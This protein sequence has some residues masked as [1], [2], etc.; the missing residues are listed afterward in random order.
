MNFLENLQEKF[1]KRFSNIKQHEILFKIIENTFQIDENKIPEEYR[2]E[3]IDLKT[4]S[5]SRFVS[6]KYSNRIL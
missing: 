4:N 3:V 6:R 5:S 2:L 1:R